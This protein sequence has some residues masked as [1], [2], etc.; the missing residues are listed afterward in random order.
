MIRNRFVYGINEV[1]IQK[2]LLIEGDKL[3]LII[4]Q[5]YETVQKMQLNS[6]C[7]MRLYHSIRIHKVQAAVAPQSHSKKCYRCARPGH[8][9]SACCFKKERC[10]KCNKIGHIKRACTTVNLRSSPANNFICE[11]LQYDI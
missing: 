6:F 11:Q 4:S 7:R 3:M 5:S 1:S 2:C 8:L 9:P 10:H